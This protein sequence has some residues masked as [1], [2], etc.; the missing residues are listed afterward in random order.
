M[1]INLI[2]DELR[3]TG[4]PVWALAEGLDVPVDTLEDWL[5]G[6]RTP[7][8]RIFVLLDAIGAIGGEKLGE[9]LRSRV[10]KVST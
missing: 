7:D 5:S 8:P 10:E 6:R 1:K 4:V 3:K 9:T 2:S